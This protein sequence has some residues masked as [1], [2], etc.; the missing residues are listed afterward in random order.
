VTDEPLSV[1][2]QKVTPAPE[3]VRFAGGMS[4]GIALSMYSREKQRTY[5]ARPNAMNHSARFR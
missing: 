4:V 5:Y 2:F 1:C 3:G